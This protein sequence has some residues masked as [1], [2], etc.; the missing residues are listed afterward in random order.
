MFNIRVF[1]HKLD[2][3]KYI[4]HL[5]V[6]RCMQ[7][8]LKRAK[9]PVWYTEGFN[10][11]IYL[12]FALPLSLGYESMS[13]SMDL[14]LM[15]AVPF[16]EVIERL[17]AALP[18]SIRVHKV[19]LQKYKPEVIKSAIYELRLSSDSVSADG[20]ARWLEVILAEPTI[21]VEK[22]TKKG[23]KLID[24]KPDIEILSREITP[25]Q[26]TLTVKTVAGID[27]NINPTLLTDELRRRADIPDL[28]CA[29]MRLRVLDGNGNDFE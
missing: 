12:T 15:T 17:N 27:K 4:S 26:L 5:D 25:E 10:P 28:Q 6:T 18:D 14:R 16:P 3:A 9:L 11:H 29:T 7:R 23:N 21:M 20:I 24:I 2:R 8:A 13:E 19:A 22:H 1:Y